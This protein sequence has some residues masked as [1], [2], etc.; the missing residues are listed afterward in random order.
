[1]PDSEQARTL[2]YLAGRRRR[3]VGDRT[4]ISNR[5]TAL[6]KLYSPQ[7][8]EWFDDIRTD[9]V[10]DFLPKWPTLEEVKEVRRTTLEKFFREHNSARKGSAGRRICSIK[11]AIALTTG[12]AVISS[13]VPTVKT[14][15][16]QIRTALSVIKEF[17]KKVAE[18]C[19]SHEGYHLFARPPGSGSVYC[20]RLLA[21]SGTGRKRFES[22]GEVARLSGIAPAIERGGESAWVRWRYFRPKFLR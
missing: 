22:A 11:E 14:L 1:M 7:A 3:V 10:C 6:L 16:Q 5:M 9:L 4:R 19:A 20:S 12:E 18:L 2:Q 13:S 8:L 17:D 21:A 15:S